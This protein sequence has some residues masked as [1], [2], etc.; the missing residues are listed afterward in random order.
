MVAGER[1]D[2]YDVFKP[3][4]HNI[5]ENDFSFVFCDQG[6]VI[7]HTMDGKSIP[8]NFEFTSNTYSD[9]FAEKGAVLHSQITSRPDNGTYAIFNMTSD[10]YTRV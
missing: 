1:S 3:Q 9:I 8:A 5:T 7:S 4:V 10:S 2:S 6:C